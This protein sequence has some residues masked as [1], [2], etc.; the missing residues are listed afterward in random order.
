MPNG[1]HH[2]EQPIV[3]NLAD[4]PIIPD[5]LSPKS[6]K[7]ASQGTAESSRVFGGG[8]SLP[9]ISQN[10]PLARAVESPFDKL[11]INFAYRGQETNEATAVVESRSI[12]RPRDQETEPT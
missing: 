6:K 11:R 2:N 12:S 4:Q 7:V 8:D 3:F 9:Q 5:P 1:E 10:L